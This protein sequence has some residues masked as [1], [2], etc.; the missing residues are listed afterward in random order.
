ME[1]AVEGFYDWNIATGA[2]EVSEPLKAI[3]GFK[4]GTVTAEDWNDRVHPKDKANYR[5]AIVRHLKDEEKRFACEYRIRRQDRRFLWIADSGICVRASDGRARRMVGA[6]RNIDA[7]KKAESKLRVARESAERVKQALQDTIEWASG[8]IVLFDRDDNI[9][10]CNQHYRMYFADAAGQAVCDMV[11]PGANFW[12]IMRAGYGNGM[13]PLI[14]SGADFE[15]YLEMRRQVRRNPA[16]P[17]EQKLSD[18]RWLQV[19]EHKTGEGGIASIYT[20]ITEMKSHEAELAEKT[21]ALEG[22]SQ[23]LSRYLSPQIYALIFSGEQTVEVTSK[24]KKLTVFFSDIADFTATADMLEPEELTTLLNQYLTE[25]STIALKHGATIDKFI[26]DAIL[27]FFGDPDTKGV[28]EDARACVRMAVAMQR[29]MRALR[30]DLRDRGLDEGFQ[31]RIGIATGFC[32]VGNF[33][34]ADRLD[35]TVIG[36]PVN[37]AARFQ[38]RAE[39]GGII[40]GAETHALVK[41]LLATEKQESLELK[42]IPRPVRTYKVVD[43][44]DD[45][46]RDERY[47]RHEQAGLRIEIDKTKLTGEARAAAIEALEQA[48]ETLKGD[49]ERPT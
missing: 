3:F 45:P 40:L 6:V 29:R 30:E 36:N 34:S 27:A 47:M 1:A 43:I 16:G 2:L 35:Y 33:G 17:V 8:G 4:T 7:R 39:R 22:L 28:K 49:A 11:K 12:E 41:D 23:K 9:V 13:F 19:V 46:S 37:L 20:D 44:Y 25:M 14:T 31:I 5:A 38:T 48:A 18:G 24:R 26:G 42:G 15:D 32:T 10:V 21:A